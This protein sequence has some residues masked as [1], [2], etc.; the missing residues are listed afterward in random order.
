MDIQAPDLTQTFP[1][2]PRDTSIAG[3]VVAARAL[4]QCQAVIAQSAG[5]FLG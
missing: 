5:G 4:D 3:Y 1:R 2:S